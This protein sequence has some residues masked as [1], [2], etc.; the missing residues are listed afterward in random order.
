MKKTIIRESFENSGENYGIKNIFLM[1]ILILEAFIRS[2]IKL[3]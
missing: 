1:Y 2:F 3:R